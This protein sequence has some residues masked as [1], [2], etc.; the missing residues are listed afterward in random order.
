MDRM[1]ANLSPRTLDYYRQKLSTFLRFLVDRGVADSDRITP[2]HI[3]AFLVHLK[4][5]H[6]PGG[7]HA[8]YRAIRTW[9]VSIS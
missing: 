6:C 8:Y 5:D 3:R 9:C 7:V 2:N 1:A 4:P